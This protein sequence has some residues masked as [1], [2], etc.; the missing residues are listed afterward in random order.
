[1]TETVLATSVQHPFTER[2]WF[3]HPPG[4][5]ILFMTETWEQF[6]YYGM[7]AILVLY[8]VTGLGFSVGRASLVYGLYTGFAYLTPLAGG[9]LSDKWLGYRRA[10]LIGGATMAAGHFMMAFPALFYPA[11][12]TIALGYGLFLPSL[13]S[14][15]GNLYADDD[16]RRRSAFS[17]YYVGLNI[18]AILAPFVCGI[19]GERWG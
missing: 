9:I 13:P 10:V 12:A 6:S 19:L 4:L 14:Q 17:L 3:G 18:G 1:M 2:T 11:L 8:M 7:R 16:P 15:V 5:T